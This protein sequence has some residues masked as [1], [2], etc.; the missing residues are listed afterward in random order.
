MAGRTLVHH[1]HQVRTVHH[2]IKF[3]AIDGDVIAYISQFL[4]HF[5][6]A[7]RKDVALVTARRSIKKVERT[8]VAAH[9]S[10]V[11]QEKSLYPVRSRFGRIRIGNGFTI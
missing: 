8:L 10:F 4:D 3:A 5:G 2:S 7:R 1:L 11:Q 9:I 6:V